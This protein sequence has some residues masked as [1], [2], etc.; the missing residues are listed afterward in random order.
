MLIV[1]A[2][3]TMIAALKPSA[4]SVIARALT[5]YL[6]VIALRTSRRPDGGG[7][8]T[9][10]GAMRLALKNGNQEWLARRL[11]YSMVDKRC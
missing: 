1:L 4:I 6:A 2:T 10:L 9:E 3:G 8:W 5:F 7:L 11:L